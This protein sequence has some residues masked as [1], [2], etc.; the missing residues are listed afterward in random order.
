MG[1]V[2][3]TTTSEFNWTTL[4]AIYS[5][6]EANHVIFKQHAFVWGSQQPRGTPTVEQSKLGF[7]RS[8]SA[9]RTRS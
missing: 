7:S 1:S 9:T 3:M 4:D 6:A 8:A 5:Y 2:Q